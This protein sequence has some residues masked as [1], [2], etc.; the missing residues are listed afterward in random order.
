MLR[1]S[2]PFVAVATVSAM[3]AVSA[4]SLSQ[5]RSAPS[6]VRDDA[7]LAQALPQAPASSSA[8]PERAADPP[9]EAP[10]AAQPGAGRDACHIEPVLAARPADPSHLLFHVNRFRAVPPGYPISPTAT[11]SPCNGPTAPDGASHDLVCISGRLSHNPSAL[12]AIA[13]ES[14][15]PQGLSL[16]HDGLPVG[17][18]GKVGFKP[19]LDEALASGFV[20]KVRSGFRSYAEQR[21][22]V[23]TWVSLE[24]QKGLG[25]EAARR[26][27]ATF[28][29]EPGH[30]EHQLGTTVDLV[31]KIPRGAM[32]EAW[33][34]RDF[35]ASP[36]IAWVRANAHRFGVVL[37][38]DRDHVA[39]TQYVYEP[40][41]YRFVGVE[42]AD[43]IK[44]CGLS[45]EEYL[46]KVHGEPP[47]QR[48]PM[49]P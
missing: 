14:D 2:L 9:A 20:L 44:R 31:F 5:A 21:T 32:Y 42:A 43:T 27:V 4:W 48:H 25:D 38:Y 47:E 33:S 8:A 29:A 16:T 34:Q 36:A 45:L 37:S 10:A 11:W 30:S 18:A 7:P 35:D 40:W 3:V 24:R 17:R 26:K 28:S 19:M 41:H 12:R 15:A 22:T 23:A 13:Y 39:T 46:A 49:A 1:R 6:P